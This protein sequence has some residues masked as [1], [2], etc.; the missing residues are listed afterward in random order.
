MSG[1]LGAAATGVGIAGTVGSLLGLGQTDVTLGGFTFS[2]ATIAVPGEMRWGTNQRL[3]RH[4]LPGGTVQINAMGV[5]WPPIAWKGIF[6]GPGAGDQAKALSTLAAG[7]ATLTL[8]W[9]DRIFLIVIREFQCSDVTAGW[10]EYSITCDVLADADQIAGPPAPPSLLQQVTADIN[11]AVAVVNQVTPYITA[12]QTAMM[13]AGSFTQGTAANAA[14]VDAI[15]A[16][17]ASQQ[18]EQTTTE[19]GIAGLG[20]GTAGANGAI[21]WLTYGETLAA[22]LAQTMAATGV[23]GRAIANLQQ[24]ST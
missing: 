3:T 21:N 9:M 7:G 24:A 10:V 19:T 18:D 5:D 13:V 23:I 4:I 12:V 16:F 14:L 20:T 11:A 8:T 22:D 2:G 15:Q 17:Q 1:F 6:D